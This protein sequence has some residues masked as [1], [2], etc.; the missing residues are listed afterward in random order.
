MVFFHVY[1]RRPDMFDMEWKVK[2]M[3][4]FP[5]FTGP[6]YGLLFCLELM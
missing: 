6:W 5:K 2:M 3:K 1:H 4:S